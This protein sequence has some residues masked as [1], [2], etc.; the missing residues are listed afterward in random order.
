[1]FVIFF[2]FLGVY[3]LPFLGFF[4]I[5]ALLRAIKKIV[6]D[7]P[8]TTELVWSGALFGIIVWT[9]TICGLTNS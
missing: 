9:I 3:V 1:M 8:Y 5:M 7:E 6:K 4:F 2:I